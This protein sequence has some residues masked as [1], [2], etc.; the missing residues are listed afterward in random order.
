SSDVCSSDLLQG[1]GHEGEH[2]RWTAPRFLSELARQRDATNDGSTHLGAENCRDHSDRLEERSKFRRQLFKTSSL[3]VSDRE[4]VPSW[5]SSLAVA[6]GFLRRLVRARVS[7][8]EVR[9]PCCSNT[10]VSDSTLCPLGYPH[11]DSSLFQVSIE[12]FCLSI[13]VVQF[14][15]TTFTGL[16]HKKC[17]RL[18]ARVVIYAYNHHVRLLSPEPMVVEQPKFTRVEEP[19]L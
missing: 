4:S 17:N 18:K 5:G 11:A 2:L 7:T 13:T 15:F 10:R 14:L 6:V 16:F 19:T 3:S 9:P 1:C 8:G 12:F